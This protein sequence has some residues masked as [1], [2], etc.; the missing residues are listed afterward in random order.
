VTSPK[1]ARLIGITASLY[2]ERSRFPLRGR[3]LGRRSFGFRRAELRGQALFQAL[4]DLL[5]GGGAG[6]RDYLACQASHRRPAVPSSEV[7]SKLDLSAGPASGDDF[8][9]IQA[10]RRSGVQA[11][12]CLSVGERG[13]QNA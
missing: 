7:E 10:F 13:D 6:G 4:Q 2:P 5:T 1:E 12:R 11:F 3:S 9:H 8:G